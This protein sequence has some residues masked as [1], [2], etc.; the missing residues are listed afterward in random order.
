MAA[1]T[2]M[3]Q[4]VP[5]TKEM[6]ILLRLGVRKRNCHGH[7]IVRE[8]SGKEQLEVVPWKVSKR[9]IAY[10]VPK[11][12]LCHTTTMTFHYSR[13]ESC[14]RSTVIVQLDRC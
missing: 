10:V 2:W 13:Y 9:E 14:S 11:S 3:S 1:L 8:L 7:S 4:K 5:G 12:N 6:A